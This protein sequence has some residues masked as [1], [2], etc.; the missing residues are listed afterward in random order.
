MS[1]R[2]SELHYPR[3]RRVRRSDAHGTGAWL[4]SRNPVTWAAMWI[5]VIAAAAWL[6]VL[7]RD[8][9]PL[10]PDERITN[11]VQSLPGWFEPLAE[12]VR[13]VTTTPVVLTVGACA[14]AGLWFAGF[15]AAAL[16]LVATL[17][18]LPFAQ[19]GLKDIV[20][21]PR[22]DAALVERKTGFTSESFPAGHV[23]SGTVLYGFVAWLAWQQRTRPA[24]RAIAVLLAALLLAN[25]AANVYMG[26]HWPTDVAGGLLWALA[27]LLPGIYVLGQGGRSFACA[28]RLGPRV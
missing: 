28:K 14:A 7:A 13:A 17:V 3:K 2:L 19:A 25:L 20:D 11:A 8:A 5:V 12:G 27:L 10:G 18:V 1:N 22:P 6:S 9:G 26:V 15:R 16:V 23:M 24:A 4:P 21:R